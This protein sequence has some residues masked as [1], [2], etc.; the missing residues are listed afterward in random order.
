MYSF[1]LVLWV[2]NEY[3]SHF[4]ASEI[5]VYLV[6]D[7][8]HLIFF[9]K[10]Y[11]LINGVTPGVKAMKYCILSLWERSH[12][13]THKQLGCQAPGF[14]ENCEPTG[15]VLVIVGRAIHIYQQLS[16]TWWFIWSMDLILNCQ[17]IIFIL[18]N[19]NMYTLYTH[20]PW[21]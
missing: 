16:S 9:L 2:H 10:S 19:T 21:C 4:S 6:I 3:F 12:D 5:N 13:L 20:F 17:Q 1:I 11:D 8:W 14:R 15:H 18:L 7:V